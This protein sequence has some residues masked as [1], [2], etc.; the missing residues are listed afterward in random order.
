MFRFERMPCGLTNAVASFQRLM[1]LLMSDLNLE[2]CLT[3]LDDLIL[4]SSTLEEH[5]KRLENY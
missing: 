1:D 3:Y 2:I 4:F 5:M